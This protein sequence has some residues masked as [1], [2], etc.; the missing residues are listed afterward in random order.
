MLDIL[1][2]EAEEIPIGSEGLVML[3]YLQGNRTPW[4]D[5]D[6]R[7]L[8]YGLSLKHTPAHV[9]RAI[10]EATCYGTALILNVFKKYVGIEEICLSGGG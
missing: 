3:E 6:V 8:L 2:R 9:Y 10:L 1:N 4:V 7:G 5:S